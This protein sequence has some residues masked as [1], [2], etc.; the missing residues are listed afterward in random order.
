[1]PGPRPGGPPGREGRHL[2]ERKKPKMNISSTTRRNEAGDWLCGDLV[3]CLDL[4]GIWEVD[5]SLCDQIQIRRLLPP[6]PG[7]PIIDLIHCHRLREVVTFSDRGD[8]L[9]LYVDPP[10]YETPPA[11]RA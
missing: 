9:P 3:T 10:S 8:K 11:V 1:G 6:A 5:G 4:P 7:E 2:M